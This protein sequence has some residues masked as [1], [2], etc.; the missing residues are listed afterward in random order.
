MKSLLL[1]LF[2]FLPGAVLTAQT[3]SYYSDNMKAN[4]VV[5][6]KTMQASNSRSFLLLATE[7]E[8]VVSH[9]LEG[10]KDKDTV[11]Q[12]DLEKQLVV[13]RQVKAQAAQLVDQERKH[14]VNVVQMAKAAAA[15]GR[16][17]QQQFQPT[18][19]HDFYSHAYEQL[20]SINSSGHW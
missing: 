7:G 5:D 2:V 14:Y 11:K 12:A 17:Q 13:I 15:A 4:V 18:T 10:V 16:A 3:I 8:E 1:L 9:Q 19:H 20:K 6:P